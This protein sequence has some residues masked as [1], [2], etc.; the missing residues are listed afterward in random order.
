M[1]QTAAKDAIRS[2]GFAFPTSPGLAPRENMMPPK[3]SLDQDSSMSLSSM[4]SS[5]D[6]GDSDLEVEMPQ[7]FFMYSMCSNE[8]KP[9]EM[10]S[11]TEPCIERSAS[12]LTSSESVSSAGRR[13]IFKQ[14]WSASNR[15][16]DASIMSRRNDDCCL[17]KDYMNSRKSILRNP[18]QK[19]SEHSRKGDGVERSHSVRFNNKVIAI[20]P[21][22][23]V[24]TRLWLTCDD[25]RRSQME[26]AYH[27]TLCDHGYKALLNGKGLLSKE[28]THALKVCYF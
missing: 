18:Y 7:Q 22:H 17:D 28:I 11:D 2:P 6:H 13:L 21:T 5:F 1:V 9:V 15:S 19:Y 20:V 27:L 26:F 25:I 16:L 10:S 14:F 8:V 12:D 23:E 3:F 4:S 24:A